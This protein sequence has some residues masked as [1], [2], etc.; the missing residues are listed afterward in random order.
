[1]QEHHRGQKNL[2]VFR[3]RLKEQE[4][5]HRS[6]KN[7]LVLHMSSKERPARHMSLMRLMGHHTNLKAVNQV[8]MLEL[9]VLHRS[10]KKKKQ[11]SVLHRNCWEKTVLYRNQSGP[12][13]LHKNLKGLIGQG[14]FHRSLLPV[15]SC[16]SR[17]AGLGRNRNQ[18]MQT[19]L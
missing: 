4:E 9:A 11:K 14:C 19:G 2:K 12:E 16:R 6:Q 7:P 3:R 15:A 10:L 13:G 18:E 1:M 5:L 8:K 17:S